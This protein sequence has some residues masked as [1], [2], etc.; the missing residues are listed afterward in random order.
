MCLNFDYQKLCNYG[1]V[2]QESKYVQVLYKGW[3][4]MQLGIEACQGTGK[5]F[6]GETRRRYTV[7]YQYLTH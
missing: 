2:P 7:D 6:Q 4:V 5:L 3:T 1:G